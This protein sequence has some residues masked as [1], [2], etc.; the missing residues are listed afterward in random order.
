MHDDTPVTPVD[1]L[2]LIWVSVNRLTRSDQVLGPEERV[3]PLEAMRA[4]TTDAA[5][6]NFEEDI[7]GSIE[8]GKLADFVILSDNP[9][10]V[11]P[12]KGWIVRRPDLPSDP[13]HRD[14][15][16][17]D[18]SGGSLDNCGGARLVES[19]MAPS[20]AWRHGAM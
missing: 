17:P 3:T 5:W 8:P 15:Q 12:L 7:K 6:Q 2:Q 20:G 16:Q 4:M 9:L 13:D 18:D 11:D 10:T 1:P 19:D 14:L